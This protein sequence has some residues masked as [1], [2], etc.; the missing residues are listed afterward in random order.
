MYLYL[1]KYK[2]DL[3]HSSVLVVSNQ[4]QLNLQNSFTMNHLAFY[5]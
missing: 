3:F 5:A 1:Y 2:Y 4:H